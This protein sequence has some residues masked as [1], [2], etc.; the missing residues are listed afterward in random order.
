MP[1]WAYTESDMPHSASEDVVSAT[2]GGVPVPGTFLVDALPKGS[3][4]IR[5]TPPRSNTSQGGLQRFAT[6]AKNEL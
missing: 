5:P 4:G 1:E 2:A 6:V 3:N